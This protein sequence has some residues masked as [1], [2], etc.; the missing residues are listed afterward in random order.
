MSIY[1]ELTFDRRGDGRY[2]SVGTGVGKAVICS[3]FSHENKYIF[4]IGV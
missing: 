3:Q 2:K 1:R 4:F